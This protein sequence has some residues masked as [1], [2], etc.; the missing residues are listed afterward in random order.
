MKKYDLQGYTVGKNFRGSYTS[1]NG[2][3]FNEKSYTIDIAGI[4]SD[5]LKLIASEIC[6]EFKQETVM[7]RDFNDGATK[8]YFVN[9]KL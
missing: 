2:M 3:V 9:D 4:D 7:V 6:R 5:A 8:V 1:K